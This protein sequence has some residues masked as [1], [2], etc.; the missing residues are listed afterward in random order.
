MC[1]LILT[2]ASAAFSSLL[3]IYTGTKLDL[4]KDAATSCKV[5]EEEKDENGN[6]R[7][8]NDFGLLRCSSATGEG[9]AA[10]LDAVVGVVARKVEEEEERLRKRSSSFSPLSCSPSLWR[11]QKRQEEEDTTLNHV[12]GTIPNYVLSQSDRN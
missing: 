5:E 8:A 4:P 10:V 3:P 11:R 1:V 12:R 9:V 7:A 6:P 2:R